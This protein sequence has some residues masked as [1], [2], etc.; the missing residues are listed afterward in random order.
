[1]GLLQALSATGWCSMVS[2]LCC[3]CT[4]KSGFF[5]QESAHWRRM[6][7]AIAALWHRCNTKGRCSTAFPTRALKEHGR[8]S[9]QLE[10]PPK[11]LAF[12]FFSR[13]SRWIIILGW[14][15]AFPLSTVPLDLHQEGSCGATVKLFLF[16]AHPHNSPVYPPSTALALWLALENWFLM[17]S[18]A[19]IKSLAISGIDKAMKPW[20]QRATSISAWGSGVGR[21]LILSFFNY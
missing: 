9:N 18:A 17:P 19:G 13:V 1:M 2:Q 8:F 21:G 14:I 16:S 12:F 10:R 3:S 20:M 4:A 15:L 5:Q 7:S 11:Q 6:D